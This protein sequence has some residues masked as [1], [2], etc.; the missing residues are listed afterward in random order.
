MFMRIMLT[1]LTSALVFL[2]LIMAINAS[3]STGSAAG[4]DTIVN[5][6]THANPYGDQFIVIAPAGWAQPVYGI[7]VTGPCAATLTVGDAW[8]AC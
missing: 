8:P 6:E 4:T 5:I 7:W 2:V 1:T 3:A